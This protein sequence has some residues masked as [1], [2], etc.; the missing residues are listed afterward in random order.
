MIA[1]I[2]FDSV[3]A[4]ALELATSIL[5]RPGGCLTD[6]DTLENMTNKVSVVKMRKLMGQAHIRVKD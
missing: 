4:D 5:S 6:T 3:A 2:S 1:G